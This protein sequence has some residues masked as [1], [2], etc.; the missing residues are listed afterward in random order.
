MEQELQVVYR[1]AVE[2]DAENIVNFYNMVGGETTFLSFEK[3]EYPLNVEAQKKA[4]C[5]M[6]EET[7]NLM[8][9][10]FVDEQIAA[11]GTIMSS[12]KV[13]SKHCGNLGIVVTHKYQ[14]QGIGLGIMKQLIAW[15][16]ENK[17]T[18]KIKLEVRTDNRKAVQM[19]QKLGFRIEGEMKND[20][21][22]N[23]RYR[24]TYVMGM[25]L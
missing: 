23:G 16:R 4:I 15:C 19:Y 13:K 6:G 11:I 20:N 12:P 10:A 2:D 21:F 14:G 3:D 7:G 22:V 25:L 17:I 18:T 24:H 5:E 1:Q 9:L 8:I